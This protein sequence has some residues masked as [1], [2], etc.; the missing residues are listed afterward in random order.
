M[1]LCT[2]CTTGAGDGRVWGSLYLPECGVDDDDYDMGVD[3][4]AASYFE[5]TL[6]VRLQNGGQD[7]ALTDGVVIQVRDVEMIADA[8]GATFDIAVEPSLDEFLEEGPGID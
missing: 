5:N 1:L 8:P 6:Q 7:Q 3:F 2:T 4:F